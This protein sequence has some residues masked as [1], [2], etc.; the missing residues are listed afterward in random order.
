MLDFTKKLL[1]VFR[2]L[3][4]LTKNRRTLEQKR[5]VITMIIQY[6]NDTTDNALQTNVQSRENL[7]SFLNITKIKL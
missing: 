3:G 5:H 1:N 4:P 2:I 6:Q 7:I